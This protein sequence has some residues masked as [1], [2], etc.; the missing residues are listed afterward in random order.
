MQS[1]VKSMDSSLMSNVSFLLTPFD[2][3]TTY[4]AI[5]YIDLCSERGLPRV[6]NIELDSE[7]RRPKGWWWL[8]ILIRT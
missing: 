5:A 2:H 3:L 1:D 4:A 7:A 6:F 8:F